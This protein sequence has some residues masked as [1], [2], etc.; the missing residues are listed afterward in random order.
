[1]LAMPFTFRPYNPD[2]LDGLQE[3]YL[4]FEPKGAYQGLPPYKKMVTQK[5]LH[6]LTRTD[7]NTHFVLVQGRRV[8]AHAALV[9][10]PRFPDSQEIIIFVH[11]DC[12]HRGWGRKLFLAAMHCACL[13]LHL[14]EVWLTVEWDNVPARTLY[15]SIGFVPLPPR[16]MTD[17]EI[18]MRRPLGCGDCLKADCPIYS[19]EL[20]QQQAGA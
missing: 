6:D 1:M 12:Q 8:V 10:Y 3:M 4:T 16:D 2:D 18:E 15:S 5:W 20:M 14:H 9:H 11:Q 7:R 13:A 17:D 19:A